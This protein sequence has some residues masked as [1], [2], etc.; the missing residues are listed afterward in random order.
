MTYNVTG[1][2]SFDIALG[3]TVRLF[4]GATQLGGFIQLDNL[5]VS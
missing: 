2:L 1:K 3:Q 5:Y 4:L